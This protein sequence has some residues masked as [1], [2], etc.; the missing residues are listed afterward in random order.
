MEATEHIKTRYNE[1]DQMGIIYHA[2]YFN[3]F[4]MAREKLFEISGLKYRALEEEGIYLPVSEVQ[5]KYKQSIAYGDEVDV[6]A[7]L[8]KF[9]GVKL[10]FEYEIWRAGAVIATGYTV[11][12]FVDRQLK[13]IAIEKERPELYTLVHQ[14]LE[15]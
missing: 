11:H 14:M 3:W 7:R 4:T 1:T 12:G 8:V 9:G 6:K 2:N 13:P 5:C 15:A 10:R